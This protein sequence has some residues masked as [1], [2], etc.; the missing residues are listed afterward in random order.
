MSGKSLAA[1]MTAALLMSMS[2]YTEWVCPMGSLVYCG[3][4][5]TSPSHGS[6]PEDRSQDA[7]TSRAAMLGPDWKARHHCGTST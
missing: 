3:A 7:G 1:S 4:S 2:K 5:M 6:S